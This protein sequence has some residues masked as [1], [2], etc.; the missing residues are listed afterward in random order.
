[1]NQQAVS[2]YR[3]PRESSLIGLIAD[4]IDKPHGDQVPR[5]AAIVVTANATAG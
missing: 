1:M 2:Q 5:N 4:T 3:Y